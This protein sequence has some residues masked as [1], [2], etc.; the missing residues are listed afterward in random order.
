MTQEENLNGLPREKLIEVLESYKDPEVFNAVTGPWKS[1]VVWQGGMRAKS[2]M[3]NHVVEMD[4]PGDLTATDVAASA[5]E[6]V[7]SAM[8]SCMTVAIIVNA[9]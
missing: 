6:Q 1:R 5:H 9:T 2:Y 7:L 8:G 4:E 3:R